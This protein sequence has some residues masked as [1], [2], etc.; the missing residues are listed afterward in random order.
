L[1]Y[2][3]PIRRGFGYMHDLLALSLSANP[4]V[5]PHPASLA[6]IRSLTDMQRK[7][8]TAAINYTAS[9]YNTELAKFGLPPAARNPSM[10]APS[11]PVRPVAPTLP[12][13][14][15]LLAPPIL[16]TT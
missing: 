5:P 16:M 13:S 1:K 3:A 14:V 8:L 4:A 2:T 9:E 15:L 6:F 12:V 10:I 11:S 7:D